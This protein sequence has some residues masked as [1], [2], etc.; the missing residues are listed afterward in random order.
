MIEGENRM[1]INEIEISIK[2]ALSSKEGVSDVLL[3]AMIVNIGTLDSDIRDRVIY[4][5][6]YELIFIKGLSEPQLQMLLDSVL[7]G[8]LLLKGIEDKQGDDV[9]TRSFVS[10]L[11]CLLMGKHYQ[12]PFMSEKQEAEVINLGLRYMES[13]KDNR[14][15][16]EGKGWAHA[17]AHGADLLGS[18]A[19]S[20]LFSSLEAERVLH[21]I[22]NSILNID[23]F[24]YGEEGRF[25]RTTFQLLKHKKLDEASLIEWIN[26]VG[27]T[28]LEKDMYNKCWT[29]YLLTLS[30]T[31]KC[32]AC[33]SDEVSH[34]IDQFVLNF[35]KK[36]RCL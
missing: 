21:I 3:N 22:E 32:E 15:F 28:I 31:L 6:F 19:E 26:K 35:Y 8:D 11:I 24:L 17:F 27:D 14:G 12:T 33:L 10:L 4:S 25:A 20:K 18:L 1:L 13:E 34:A 5:G 2:N 36:Y 7:S 23:N 16:V 29:D 9:F 30:F